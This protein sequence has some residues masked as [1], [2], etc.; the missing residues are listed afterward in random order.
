M[1]AL[2]ECMGESNEHRGTFA[3]QKL[4]L[5]TVDSEVTKVHQFE[6]PS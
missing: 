3:R 5:Y 1:N 6:P 4:S 2:G